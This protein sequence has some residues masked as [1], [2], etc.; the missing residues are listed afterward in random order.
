MFYKNLSLMLFVS[1]LTYSNAYSKTDLSYVN[2]T[3]QNQDIY[4][5]MNPNILCFY[6]KI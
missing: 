6:N 5:E 3:K 4:K 1:F 2:E